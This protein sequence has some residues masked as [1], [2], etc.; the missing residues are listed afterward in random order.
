MNMLPA[1]TRHRRRISVGR[2]RHVYDSPYRTMFPSRGRTSRRR[3]SSS[4]SCLSEFH[5]GIVKFPLLGKRT[6][7]LPQRIS[8]SMHSSARF[9]RTWLR[10]RNPTSGVRRRQRSECV[11]LRSPPVVGTW[12]KGRSSR[13][14]RNYKRAGEWSSRRSRSCLCR[15]RRWASV[16]E[17]SSWT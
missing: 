13:L 11:R 3:S 5:R 12:R 10:W 4:R 17:K 1:F 6:C 16:G 7:L 2:K 14:W 15:S 9:P 8:T